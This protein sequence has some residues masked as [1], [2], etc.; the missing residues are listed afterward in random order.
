MQLVALI[1]LFPFLLGTAYLL[2][3]LLGPW[4]TLAVVAIAGTNP[5]LSRLATQVMS[6]VPYAAVSLLALVA[7]HLALKAEG[8]KRWILA[9]TIAGILPLIRFQGAVL[10]LA[11]ALFLLWQRRWRPLLA[12]CGAAAVLTLCALAF[13]PTA[14]WQGGFNERFGETLS[15]A[16]HVAALATSIRF[17]LLAVLPGAFTGML[18]P[19]VSADPMLSKP[20][21]WQALG[22]AAATLAVVVGLLRALPRR[23]TAGA[24]AL[25]L[26][27][28]LAL[29]TVWDVNFVFL[30]F[31]QALRLAL[32]LL[33]LVVAIALLALPTRV[34]S[35]V[36]AAGLALN[37]E[38]A[39]QFRD[40]PYFP[41]SR[42][43]AYRQ[44]FAY[45]EAH[46]APTA[47]V[48]SFM[49]AMVYLYTHREGLSVPL[50]DPAAFAA[51]ARSQGLQAV[52]LAHGLYGYLD[53][54]QDPMQRFVDGVNTRYPGALKLAYQDATTGME[55]WQV[56]QAP[57]A[58][59]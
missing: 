50:A 7:V 56:D 9:G 16:E 24:L 42:C 25:Y 33:P 2:K 30:G 58:M 29:I 11:I 53:R 39:W 48:G 28:S 27:C 13:S 18:A 52:F 23:D 17:T 59:P 36:L 34:G 47:R 22:G 37:L 38:T 26:G 55:V 32:P 10:P 51:L 6:D 21:A 41:P 49:P 40:Q 35:L 20:T 4:Q 12:Y 3:S 5:W 43:A 31:G 54:S 45:L 14:L 57:L 46:T 44:A 1:S 8:N 19:P 15:P